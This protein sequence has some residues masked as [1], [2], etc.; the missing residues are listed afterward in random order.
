MPAIVAIMCA[1]SRSSAEPFEDRLLVF[2]P[3]HRAVAR[4]RHV[5]TFHC[6]VAA[7]IFSAQLVPDVEPGRDIPHALQ[8]RQ[9]AILLGQIRHQIGRSAQAED[10]MVV[11]DQSDLPVAH[12]DVAR[13]L[14][15]RRLGC[16]HHAQRIADRAALP[17]HHLKKE[18]GGA[19]LIA[20]ED[21]LGQRAKRFILTYLCAV[22]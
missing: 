13:H 8:Q 17:R 19:R 6:G 12:V 5:H 21:G 22:A 14:N 15:K 16:R 7:G 20:F 11:V 18:V 2:V 3:H 9:Q 10:R 4:R 1:C